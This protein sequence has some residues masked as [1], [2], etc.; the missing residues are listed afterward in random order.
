[1][2]LQDYLDTNKLSYGAF[3][4]LI[5][6]KNGRT[7]HRYVKGLRHPSRKMIHAIVRETEG[8]VTVS[9]LVGIPEG[10]D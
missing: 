7:V 6:A 9:D 4:K 2:L 1:M 3:A 5:G 8:K 10:V